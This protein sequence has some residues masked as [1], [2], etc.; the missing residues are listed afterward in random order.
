MPWECPQLKYSKRKTSIN[1]SINMLLGENC[2]VYKLMKFLKKVRLNILR[3]WTQLTDDARA[4]VAVSYS[5]VTLML[6]KQ[7]QEYPKNI[8]AWVTSWLATPSSPWTTLIGSVRTSLANLSTFFLNVAENRRVCLSGL[9]WS[10]IDRTCN[11]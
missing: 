2:E 9:T 1:S 10:Q 4:K 6:G 8:H 11:K 7:I 5:Q 3:N